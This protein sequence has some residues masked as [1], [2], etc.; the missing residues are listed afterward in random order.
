MKSW[1]L[2]HGPKAARGAQAGAAPFNSGY[3]ELPE[4]GEEQDRAAR[5]WLWHVEGGRVGGG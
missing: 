1:N 3:A 2:K 4:Q 5:E